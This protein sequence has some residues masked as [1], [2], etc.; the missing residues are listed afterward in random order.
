MFLKTKHLLK[1]QFIVNPQ[2]NKGRTGKRWRHI[3]EA[4]SAFFKEFKYEF[5]DKPLHAI[6]ISRSAIKEGSELIIAI[7]GDGTVNEIANGFFE[8]LKIINPQTILGLI[9]SGT[10]CDLSR[11][12][13]IPNRL[14]HALEIITQAPSALIDIGRTT[15]IN[16]LGQPEER[17][18][19]NVGDFG[20]GGEVVK[21]VNDNRM[22]RKAS[23]YL[24]CLLS[25][26]FSYRNK[27]IK[28]K[29]DGK[30]L[31][32]DEYLIGA[33]AN[34]KIFGKGMKIAP[35]AKLND[36]YF[37]IILIKGM[38]SWQFL[39]NAYRLYAGTHLSLPQIALIRGKNIEAASLEGDE[40]LIELDG[41]QL[42]R[43]PANF[44]ILPSRIPIIGHV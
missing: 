34:G 22:K 36:G 7:G 31:P 17:M 41:E 30:D 21:R 27:K 12:L 39:L 26:F 35:N 2:S 23:S 14:K 20:V 43:L 25:V 4:L 9:P 1:P 42:G 38:K 13:K 11:S 29:I 37:D 3:K 19:L 18:F 10:G 33:V 24:K 28:I 5:T 8:N 40:V 15:F 32:L 44:E 16:H 6:E